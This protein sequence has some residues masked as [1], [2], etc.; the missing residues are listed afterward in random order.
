MDTDS[1][2]VPIGTDHKR[3]TWG[4]RCPS[5]GNFTAPWRAAQDFGG[6]QG[7][8]LVSGPHGGKSVECIWVMGLDL[9]Y[10]LQQSSEV[11]TC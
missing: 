8:Q 5:L 1:S 7:I 9:G 6:L 4:Q 11:A 10:V 2:K 3:V